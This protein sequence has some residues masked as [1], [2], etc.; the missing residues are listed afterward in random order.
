MELC[1]T[2]DSQTIFDYNAG[3]FQG[4]QPNTKLLQSFKAFAFIF[5]L[6]NTRKRILRTVQCYISKVRGT[7]F[8]IRAMTY[9]FLE[10]ISDYL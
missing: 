10:L 5:K 1:E 7:V 6:H 9:L 4:L 8:T 2:S 3:K